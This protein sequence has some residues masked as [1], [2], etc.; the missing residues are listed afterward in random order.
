MLKQPEA[1]LDWR[2]LL[3]I[4][5]EFATARPR[6]ARG[7]QRRTVAAFCASGGGL[8]HDDD[9]VRDPILQQARILER[10]R[11]FEEAWGL[12]DRLVQLDRAARARSGE[13]D[14]EVRTRTRCAYQL[15]ADRTAL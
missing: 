7:G 14:D 12:L 1:E 8:G 4:A 13:M 9:R 3:S 6:S 11:R 2:W 15:A 10:M 5:E